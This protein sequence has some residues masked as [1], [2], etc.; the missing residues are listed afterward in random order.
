VFEI[1]AASLFCCKVGYNKTP[2]EL[3]GWTEY[4]KKQINK[5]VETLFL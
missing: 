1:Q 2:D 3:G 5:Q 4:Y